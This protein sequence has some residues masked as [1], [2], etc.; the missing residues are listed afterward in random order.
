MKKAILALALLCVGTIPPSFAATKRPKEI[1]CACYGSSK[2]AQ[3]GK[4]PDGR[5]PVCM[6]K[7]STET[8]AIK[9]PPRRCYY[10]P[11]TG[12]EIFCTG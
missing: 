1:P 5:P 3:N 7:V 6:V 2:P 10:D 11:V 8:P 4:C 9:D 12:R